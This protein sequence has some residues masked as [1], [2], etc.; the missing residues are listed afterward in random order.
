MPRQ[1]LVSAKIPSEW[2]EVLTEKARSTGSTKSEV[3][4]AA[5]AAYLGIEAHG[6]RVDPVDPVDRTDRTEAIEKRLSTVEQELTRLTALIEQ[7]PKPAATPRPRPEASIAP[8]Q[9]ALTEGLVC[10]VCG[11]NDLAKWGLGKLRADGT[12]AQRY[13]CNTCRKVFT[14]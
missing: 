12:Q 1:E 8:S 11:S 10:K 14:P 9:D 7:A 13:K 2:M 6:V 3:I 4:K 5:I